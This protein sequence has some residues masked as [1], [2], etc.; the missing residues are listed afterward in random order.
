MKNT[1]NLFDDNPAVTALLYEIK[2]D[3]EQYEAPYS[4]YHE[5]G[6]LKAELHMMAQRFPQVEAYLAEANASRVERKRARS[7]EIHMVQTQPPWL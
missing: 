3:A 4:V 2:S 6:A 7:R 1:K 5:L